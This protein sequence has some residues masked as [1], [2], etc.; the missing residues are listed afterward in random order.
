MI[1]LHTSN[2]MTLLIHIHELTVTQSLISEK[3][4]STSEQGNDEE[5]ILK[6]RS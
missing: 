1:E 5:P 3:R 2:T 6:V 4:T